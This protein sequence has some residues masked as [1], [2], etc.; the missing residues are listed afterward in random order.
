MSSGRLS[1]LCIALC[2]TSTT[3]SSSPAN[4]LYH[5]QVSVAPSSSCSI[6]RSH[7]PSSHLSYVCSRINPYPLRAGA[8]LGRHLQSAIWDEGRTIQQACQSHLRG[9]PNKDNHL[10]VQQW[11][12]STHMVFSSRV[13][14]QFIILWQPFGYERWQALIALHSTPMHEK[15]DFFLNCQIPPTSPDCVD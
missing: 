1:L 15:H 6:T 4:T 9:N 14:S 11:D 3:I 2:C 7:I 12:L 8:N 5:V 10:V 13:D